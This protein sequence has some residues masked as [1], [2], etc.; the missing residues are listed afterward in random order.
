MLVAASYYRIG[1]SLC[2]AV[3]ARRVRVTGGSAFHLEPGTI[4]KMGLIPKNFRKGVKY[5]LNSDLF[6]NT[7]LRGCGYLHRN[8]LL[9]I[10]LT[11][12]DDLSIYSL[13]PAVTSLRSNVGIST[14]SNHPV[15]GSIIVMQVRLAL[16]WMIATAGCYW[17]ID[18][19]YGPIRSICTESHG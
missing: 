12:S 18:L 11:L 17:L 8:V 14:I 4:V 5:S 2:L 10:W 15:A 7:T 13:L 3:R 9:N 6:L 1:F 19:L 16:F